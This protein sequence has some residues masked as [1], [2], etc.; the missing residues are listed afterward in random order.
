MRV[1]DFKVTGTMYST[2]DIELD[3]SLPL[4]V[5]QIQTVVTTRNNF[6]SEGLSSVGEVSLLSKSNPHTTGLLQRPVG[7]ER[8]NNHLTNWPIGPFQMRLFA[9]E[10]VVIE[11][12]FQF[13]P[14]TYL[15][16]TRKG[17]SKGENV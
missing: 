3:S 2:P 12:F 10:V 9:T 15:K 14:V 4:L 8:Q 5:S 7:L 11:I 6:Q 1:C 13:S 16:F 17:V